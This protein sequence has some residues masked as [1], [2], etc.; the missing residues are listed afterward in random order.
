MAHI[1]F[2]SGLFNVNLKNSDSCFAFGFWL[3]KQEVFWKKEKDGKGHEK[4]TLTVTEESLPLEIAFGSKAIHSL[5]E[6]SVV[7]SPAGPGALPCMNFTLDAKTDA[8][9]SNYIPA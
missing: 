7:A 6:C 9:D 8:Q 1:F 4:A 3:L 2:T 5:Q